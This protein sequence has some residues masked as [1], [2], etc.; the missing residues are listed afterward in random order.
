LDELLR[1]L[2]IKGDDISSV[3]I[4]KGM[5]SA[6]HGGVEATNTEIVYRDIVEE[7]YV[8]CLGYR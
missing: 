2:N 8:F 3:F 4:P 5:I 1:S 6:V 7:D